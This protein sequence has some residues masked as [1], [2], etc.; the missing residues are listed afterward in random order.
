MVSQEEI[1]K[2][3]RECLDPELGIN[4]IDL[5]LIYS[6]MIEDSRVNILMT[7]TAPDCP[8]QSYFIKDISEKL[9]LV[10][11]VSDVSVELT[12]DPPWSSAKMSAESQ[13]VLHKFHS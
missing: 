4:I 7:L 10:K 1:M 5:G 6:I 11:G 13:E 8:L 12:F 2:K 3:L 9:K